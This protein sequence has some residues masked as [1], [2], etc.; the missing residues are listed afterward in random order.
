MYND[1]FMPAPRESK[2]NVEFILASIKADIRRWHELLGV[3]P[4]RICLTNVL[5]EAIAHWSGAARCY[6]TKELLEEPMLFGIP[7]SRYEPDP[8]DGSL[9][10]GYYLATP[11]R[12]FKFREE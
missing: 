12:K 9:A 1:I 8:K 11:E 7:V 4:G 5:Y 6:D 3:D 10:V 2:Y